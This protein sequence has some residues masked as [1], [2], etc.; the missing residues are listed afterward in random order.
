MADAA[1]GDPMVPAPHVVI[2]RTPETVDTT[3]IV[4]A[5]S[6]APAAPP[7]PGQFHMLGAFGTGEVPIS[8]SALGADGAVSHTVRAVGAATAALAAVAPGDAVGVRG[9][10]GSPWG[11]E[12]A[13]GGDL[14]LVAGGIGLA[15][16]RPVL[17]RVVADRA[18]FGRVALLVGARTPD[19][20]L[21]PDELARTRGVDVQ[22]EVTVDHARRG[23][24]GD[25]GLVTD[26]VARAEV[27]P[28]RTTAM[29]CGPEVMMRRTVA[30]LLARDVDPD[31]IEVSLE[32]NMQCAL[33]TCG[34][35]QLGPTFIC[36]DGPVFAWPRVESLLRV[37]ER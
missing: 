14:V 1:P 27:D 15:P 20:V 36:R 35:C 11:I 26:L 7:A 21:F 34:H 17:H 13:R 37:R 31:R 29:V 30:A 33:G 19:A 6:A 4:L 12:A 32:R 5:A 3:T 22:V 8:V 16:L 28:A 10:F 18:T 24:T 25:V 23:W 2:G 9:P